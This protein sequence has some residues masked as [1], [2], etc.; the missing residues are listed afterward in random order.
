MAFPLST[1]DKCGDPV[2]TRRYQLPA[3]IEFDYESK[4]YS[5]GLTSFHLCS[6]CILPILMFLSSY[7]KDAKDGFTGRYCLQSD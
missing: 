4:E 6:R 2:V 3:K 5:G 1:C 7:L